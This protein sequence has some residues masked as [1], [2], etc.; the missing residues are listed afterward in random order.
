MA[1]TDR[2]VRRTRLAL[3][4]A[5]VELMVD[6]GYDA[7]TVQDI[8]DRA[9]V[10]RS[11]FYAHFTDKEHLFRSGIQDLQA[12]LRKACAGAPAGRSRSAC[13]CSGTSTPT[14]TSTGR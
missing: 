9:D 12:E 1:S 13:P 14:S 3:R 4:H 8:I 5:L 11:T 6:K 7:V 2:R 10:G